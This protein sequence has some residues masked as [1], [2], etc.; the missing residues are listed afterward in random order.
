MF[1]LVS[2]LL[3]VAGFVGMA[4]DPRIVLGMPNWAKSTKFGLSLALYGAALLWLLPYATRW[5]RA[6]RVVAGAVGVLLTVEIV[7]LVFQ[8]VR[9]VPIHFNIATPLDTALWA[10]MSVT[11]MVFW[12]VS[13]VGALLM[14]FQPFANRTLAWGIRLGLF[15]TL[16]GFAEGFLMTSPNAVQQTALAAGQHL[17][18][19]G[20]HTVNGF[21]GGPGLPLLGWSTNHGDLRI[22]HFVGI[23]AAQIIPLLA[24]LLMRIPWLP[25]RHQWVVLATGAAGYLGLMALATWQALRDQPL[26]APDALTLAALGGLVLA[27]AVVTL[28]T[29]AHARQAPRYATSPM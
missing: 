9:G 19:V 11:I 2:M 26:L 27:C 25:G 10:I 28:A 1:T 4:V 24:V 8:A 3:A 5:P 20:A 12:L 6:I 18:L 22:G 15:I 23:H 21:D 7:L 13:A 14:L 17:T 16:I 29:F